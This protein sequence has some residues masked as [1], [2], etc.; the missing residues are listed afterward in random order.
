MSDEGQSGVQCPEMEEDQ[1]AEVL[2]PVRSLNPAKQT[3]KVK[4]GQTPGKRDLSLNETLRQIWEDRQQNVDVR[5]LHD[6]IRGDYVFLLAE[7]WVSLTG[8]ELMLLEEF[9][10]YS[11]HPILD[12]DVTALFNLTV[13]DMWDMLSSHEGRNWIASYLEETC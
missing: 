11:A 5:Y 12:P 10:D 2:A 6:P 1:E 4:D 8:N 7:G 13:D 3:I 9:G